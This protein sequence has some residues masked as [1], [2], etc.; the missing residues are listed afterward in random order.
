MRRTLFSLAALIGILATVLIPTQAGAQPVEPTEPAEVAAAESPAGTDI[1]CGFVDVPYQSYYSESSCWLKENAITNG[2][3]PTTYGPTGT[4]TR[5]QT[6]A[7]LWRSAGFPAAASSCGFTDQAQIQTWARQGACWLKAKGG[8]DNNT[9]YR[10]NDNMTRAEMALMLWG[11]NNKPASLSPC[12]FSDTAQIPTWARQ[13]ACWLKDKGITTNN[14]YRPLAN[15][16]RAEMSAFLW[17][18]AG[19]PTIKNNMAGG[20]AAV[21]LY[22]V[23]SPSAVTLPVFGNG[24]ISVDWGDGT[25]LQT[26]S[27]NFSQPTHNYAAGAFTVKVTGSASNFGFAPWSGDPADAAYLPASRLIAVSSF[28]SLN[29]TSMER[30]FYGATELVRVPTSLPSSVTSLASAFTGPYSSKLQKK[31]APEKFN[32]PS[33]TSWN[34]SNVTR[35]D[36]MFSGATAFN[37]PIG[38]WNTSKVTTMIFAF[39]SAKFFNQPLNNWNTV[40]VTDM[41]GMFN[42]AEFFNQP[43][44]NWN[45]SKVASFGYMFARAYNFNQPIGNWNTS[46][47]IVMSSMFAYST[48]N[49]PIGN[50]NTSKVVEMAGMFDSAA[51]NQ[52]I[53][54]WNTANVESMDFMFYNAPNFNQ[55]IGRWNTSKVKGMGWM[56]KNAKSFNQPLANWNTAQVADMRQMFLNTTFNQPIGNWN[57]ANV[58]NMSLMFRNSRFNQPIGN[59]NTSNVV[60]M[61][62][63]FY[64][65]NFNQNISGWNVTKVTSY[66]RFRELSLLTTANTPPKFR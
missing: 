35:M 9:T 24:N 33:V 27:G 37:Q 38:N 32:D 5:A 18:N 54:N 21:L 62:E 7:F 20:D 23:P 66:A 61:Q 44:N 50:W 36:S 63:M 3:S 56:F 40:N 42:Q 29:P 43:L 51:F 39:E 4:V 57:T 22:S 46:N 25:P 12:G 14:P 10:P 48:F 31:Y 6:A 2:T 41:F 8:L 64:N 11:A 17:R 59:W 34:T 30:A 13:G 16:T 15:V 49:Q 45:T 28:G 26:F 65:T 52:S 53:E 19:R 47:A 60:N 58:Q 55:P 1:F